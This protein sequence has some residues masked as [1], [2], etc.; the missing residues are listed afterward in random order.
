MLRRSDLY[1]SR[2]VGVDRMTT[3]E[4]TGKGGK[5]WVVGLWVLT[6]MES[7]MMVL[8]GSAKF[9]GPDFWTTSFESWGYS[10]SFA[11]VIGAAEVG[12]GL[13]LLL[14]RLATYAATLLSVIMIGAVVTVTIHQSDLG[15]A[16]ALINLL[17]LSVIAVARRGKRWT[18]RQP[19]PL[20]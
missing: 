1:F 7:A 11:F 15:V 13:L 5:A 4:T 14:P 6:V 3:G 20:P 8:A 16:P 17:L 9:T 18:P 12:G 19:L 10:A 2:D